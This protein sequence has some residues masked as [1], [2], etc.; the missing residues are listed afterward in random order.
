MQ[1]LWKSGEVSKKRRQIRNLI[2]DLAD[3]QAAEKL[4]KEEDERRHE[5]D[6]EQC[7]EEAEGKKEEEHKAEAQ[8]ANPLS[9]VAALRRRKEASPT[10]RGPNNIYN[11]EVID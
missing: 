8:R 9:A 7:E 3:K 4:R 10:R 5:E 6:E 1:Q 2:R 11:P